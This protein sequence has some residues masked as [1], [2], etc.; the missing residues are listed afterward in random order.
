VLHY[1][2]DI[3]QDV[4]QA[5]QEM[6]QM[7]QG[8]DQLKLTVNDLKNAQGPAST[9]TPATVGKIA[10]TRLVHEGRWTPIQPIGEPVL[11]AQEAQELKAA[12][13]SAD[14]NAHNIRR[15]WAL[16]QKLTPK[17]RG[18]VAKAAEKIQ[19]SLVFVNSERHFWTLDPHGG[20]PTA[21]DF[22]I[23]H[24]CVW[25]E[26]TSDVDK[27]VN[28]DGFCFG[29]LENW[30]CRDC[31]E[32]VGEC[33]VKMGP[34]EFS[35]LGEGLDYLARIAACG[36]HSR[37]RN[38][39]TDRIESGRVVICDADKFYLVRAVNGFPHE[40]H[41]G[42][43]TDRGSAEAFV[44][45]I[46]SKV[47]R[48]WTSALSD[49]C[50]RAL[51]HLDLPEPGSKSCC[52]LGSGAYGRVFRARDENHCGV[53]LKLALDQ[54]GIDAISSEKI[55]YQN[56]ALGEADATTT[57]IQHVQNKCSAALVIK[58]LGVPLPKTRT[59]IA[60]ALLGLLKLSRQGLKHGDARVC[61]AIWI[62]T[63]SR[64][65]W[66]D[67]HTLRELSPGEWEEEF[68][69]EVATF[70]LSLDVAAEPASLRQ[71]ALA[72]RRDSA[73][74]PDLKALADAFS[75][76]FV[77]LCLPLTPCRPLFPCIPHPS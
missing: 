8:M 62:E 58:P 5:K 77:S 50:E 10:Y 55:A 41:H 17:L 1:L 7:K 36:K 26:T 45:F 13:S 53:A 54:R 68:V 43:W 29:L 60:S 30:D 44:D 69:S 6:E 66:T 47:D 59:S 65:L 12:V 32:V 73:P 57:M 56:E 52:I 33:K 27:R 20:A 38:V 11:T 39:R 21:P 46:A 70:A 42:K 19:T 9:P 28:G 67:L 64:A 16:M 15:E 61:N 49:I 22:F 63:E 72:V 34:D 40:C 76:C 71:A 14:V 35:A 24:P 3:N 18:L 75:S 48:A 25:K 31:L 2:Q 74:S 37:H 23:T 4:K 51:I